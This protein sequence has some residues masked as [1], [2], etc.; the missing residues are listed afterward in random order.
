MGPRLL[1]QKLQETRQ[2]PIRRRRALPTCQPTLV[3]QA[4]AEGA[5]FT[6]TRPWGPRPQLQG[7][8]PALVR[9]T[10]QHPRDDA[11][12]LPD[13][14]PRTVGPTGQAIGRVEERLQVMCQLLPVNCGAAGIFAAI[15]QLPILQERHRTGRQRDRTSTS[16]HWGRHTA[17]RWWGA[18]SHAPCHGP[19]GK[20]HWK[21]G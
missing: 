11:H 20:S 5:G 16:A 4:P 19:K 8:C 9:A 21:V 10:E 1:L 2:D 18:H 3:T 15:N 12:Q 13:Y 7:T 6:D 14:G 17:L